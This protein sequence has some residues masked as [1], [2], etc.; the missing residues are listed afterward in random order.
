MSSQERAN[1]HRYVP[2]VLGAAFLLQAAASLSS[3]AV[4][5]PLIVPGNI[6]E[7]MNNVANHVLRARVSILLELITAVGIVL[8]GVL[9]YLTLEKQNRKAALAAMALYIMEATL[10]AASRV[11][12]FSFLRISQ[13]SAAAGHP[14]YLQS[15]GNL[16][17]ESQVFGYDLHMIPFTI[18]AT[19]F[20]T[21]LVK[22]GYIPTPLALFGLAA[23]AVALIFSP[24]VLLGFDIPLIVFLPNLPFELGVGIW[25]AAKGIKDGAEGG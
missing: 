11:E 20:Y 4:F 8:L 25:L 12:A 16:F 2:R 10:L 9:L 5:D 6:V 23:A 18:G 17:Y 21:L 22:S 19:I 14:A 1:F 7:S 3:Y 13:E 24:L 15:L